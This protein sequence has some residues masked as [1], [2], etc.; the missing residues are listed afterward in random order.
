[1]ESVHPRLTLGSYSFGDIILLRSITSLHPGVGRGGEEVDLAVQRD[2]LGFPIIYASSIK[3]ALK[4]AIWRIDQKKAK[5]LLGPETEE[6]EKYA[7]PVGV[8]D[9]FLLAM[10]ARSLVGVYAFLTTPLLLQRFYDIINFAEAVGVRN[11]EGLKD[12]IKQILQDLK[13][14]KNGAMISPLSKLRVD[15]LNGKLVLNEEFW[16][17]PAERDSVTKLE[18]E[19]KMEEG[20]LVVAN[21]DVGLSIINR[22]LIRVTRVKLDREKKTVEGGGLWTEEHVPLGTI[23]YTVFFYSRPYK[24]I[25]DTDSAENVG[26]EM[27]RLIEALGNYLVIG[28]HESVGR[29]IVK[30]EFRG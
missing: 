3:G 25:E 21:D 20:R 24:A 7:S 29:G 26:R 14:V 18:H 13:E 28:G 2:G 4:T 19:L 22:S 6:E 12:L 9:A 17:Q 15:A 27:R 10:P 1:M 16:L 11:L 23:F 8:L 30:L 5:L